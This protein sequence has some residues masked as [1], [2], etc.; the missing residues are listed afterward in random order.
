MRLLPLPSLLSSLLITSACAGF[1]DDAALESA[2]NHEPVDYAVFDSCGVAIPWQATLRTI[3]L[4]ATKSDGSSW[5]PDATAAD[6]MAW[7]DLPGFQGGRA[8]TG[9]YSVRLGG[10]DNLVGEIEV[11]LDLAAISMNDNG[12]DLAYDF[13]DVDGMFV[14]DSEVIGIGGFRVEC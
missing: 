8:R 12:F 13:R 5:D 11:G 4:P 14:W 1:G 9:E 6:L 3:N 10:G 2:E 7:F